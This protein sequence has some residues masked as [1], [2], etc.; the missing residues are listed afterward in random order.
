[1]GWVK[2]WGSGRSVPSLENSVV[3]VSERGFHRRASTQGHM[4]LST[5]VNEDPRAG[6]GRKRRGSGTPWAHGHLRE[7]KPKDTERE[8]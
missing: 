7:G 4:K 6:H 2:G 8:W 1:M 3:Q 5:V